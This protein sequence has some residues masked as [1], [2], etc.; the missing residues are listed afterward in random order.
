MFFKNLYR[1]LA[2]LSLLTVSASVQPQADLKSA[3]LISNRSTDQILVLCY[4]DIVADDV[5]DPDAGSD[6]HVSDFKAQLDYLQNEGYHSISANQYFAHRKYGLNLPEKPVLLTFDDG[7]IGNYTTA[8]P[9]LKEQ[10]L[11]ATFFVH[12]HYV[13][14]T[15]SK[16]HMTWDQLREIDSQKQFK[17]YAHTVTHPNLTTLKKDE[18]LTSEL[19]DSRAEVERN[20]GGPRPFLAYPYGIYDDR[21]LLFTQD[22]YALAFTLED[23]NRVNTHRLYQEN[24][25]GV[26][27]AL[28]SLEDFKKAL[29]DYMNPQ[30]TVASSPTPTAFKN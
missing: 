26:N 18:D 10:K 30:P 1:R 27:R 23:E 25:L 28:K 29:N 8:L 19:R 7:Y 21:V 24:R 3:A 14:T 12:T 2:F 9:I 11:K 15:T 4:H 6:T 5:N 13:G 22:Y 20:L 17:V 16:V